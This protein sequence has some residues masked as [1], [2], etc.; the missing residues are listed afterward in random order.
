MLGGV[1]GAGQAAVQQTDELRGRLVVRAGGQQQ[2]GAEPSEARYYLLHQ[3]PTSSLLHQNWTSNDVFQLHHVLPQ[4]SLSRLQTLANSCQSLWPL[5]EILDTFVD[6]PSR[7]L[8]DSHR[9]EIVLC[10]VEELVVGETGEGGAVLV[11]PVVFQ[12]ARH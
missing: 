5:M 1:V 12:P 3:G 11:Q 4:L 2:A 10:E 6:F 9:D 7:A 8:G